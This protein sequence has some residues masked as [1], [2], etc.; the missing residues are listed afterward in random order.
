VNRTHRRKG[1]EMMHSVAAIRSLRGVRLPAAAML[2]GLLAAGAVPA[3]EP[4]EVGE[5]VLVKGLATVRLPGE[6]PRILGRGQPL[7]ETEVLDTG[8]KS[9]A[10]IRLGDDTRLTLRPRTTFAIDAYRYRSERGSGLLRLLRGGL[11]AVT[12]FLSKRAP[13]ALRLITPVATIGIR[14]TTFDARLCAGDCAEET[15][16]LRRVQG[17]PTVPVIGR[18]V[19]LHGRLEATS[20]AGSARRLFRGGPV[21]QGDTLATEAGSAAVVAFRDA[22]RV[23]LEPDT[24]FQVERY[25]FNRERPATGSAFFRLIRGGLRAVTGLIARKR[26]RF[27]RLI[28]PVATIGIRG[29]GFDVRCRGAC[30]E[31]EAQ[32]GTGPEDGDAA[33]PMA[34]GKEAGCEPGQSF[35]AYV[36]QGEVALYTGS[37]VFALGEE[38]AACMSSAEAPPVRL[39][40]VPRFLRENPAERPDRV[41]FDPGLFALE[42]EA[43][44]ARPGLYVTVEDGHVVIEMDE[45]RID[46]GGGESGYASLE[47]GELF[48]FARPPLFMEEDPYPRPDRIEESRASG[49]P[50]SGSGA[51]PGAPS[52]A[53]QAC[54]L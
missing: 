40:E 35:H 53:P 1:K 20:W 24:R 3:A 28:T 2:L 46:L 51:G 4:P 8:R 44:T 54:T 43:E 10:V 33:A 11:R 32:V 13:D 41:P 5:V 36:W 17:V 50:F 25:D 27:F 52:E 18:V 42:S 16:S 29:T 15:R 19:V 7:R 47:R 22:T 23:T 48:R 26:R 9:F 49:L 37:G 31:A 39:P 34:S 21:Y 45:R 30:A 38:Q 14:G 6:A 12:G